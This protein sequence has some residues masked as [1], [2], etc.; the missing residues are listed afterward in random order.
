MIFI[1]D[2]SWNLGRLGN[3]MFMHAYG[4]FLAEKNNL[5]W[6]SKIE[7]EFPNKS[8]IT[9]YNNGIKKEIELLIKDETCSYFI[10][11]NIK[12]GAEIYG[13]FQQAELVNDDKY[14]EY[15]SSIFKINKYLD[16]D[17]DSV[18]I[19]IRAGDL[20]HLNSYMLPYEYYESQLESIQFKNGVIASDTLEHPTIEKLIKK[21]NF[22][23]FSANP[24]ETI[25]FG[26]SH[27]K[28]ILS[29]GTF[30]YW[31]GALSRPGTIIKNITMN[32]AIEKYSLFWWHPNFNLEKIRKY[33]NTRCIK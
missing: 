28:L 2:K 23:K 15:L 7:D 1:S 6:Q 21:Y 13:W 24:E 33:V 20:S 10:N 26:A 22:K 27:S 16:I 8:I 14:A 31:I 19:H 4:N 17:Q 25:K 18:F 12:C 9:R 11:N 5:Y 3:K 32:E 29:L 30:S